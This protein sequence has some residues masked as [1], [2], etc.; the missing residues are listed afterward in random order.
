M[1]DTTSRQVLHEGPWPIAPP[2]QLRRGA[3]GGQYLLSDGTLYAWDDTAN[4][5]LPIAQAPGCTFF[6]EPSPGLWLFADA[7]SI[8]RVRLPPSG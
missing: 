5:L 7:T 8:Y 4:T 3:D 2:R 6:T 1:I